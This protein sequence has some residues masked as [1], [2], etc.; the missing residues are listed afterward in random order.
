MTVKNWAV[1]AL[2]LI[3]AGC[4][5]Q[6]E[7]LEFVGTSLSK[8]SADGERISLFAA[9]EETHNGNLVSLTGHWAG[10][11][12]SSWEVEYFGY[13]P[14][15][16]YSGHALE[17][18][19]ARIGYGISTDWQGFIISHRSRLEYR[20]GQ[21]DEAVRYRPEVKV[22]RVIPVGESYRLPVYASYEAA[23]NTGDE[24]FDF[25]FSRAGFIFPVSKS[26][27]IEAGYLEIRDFKRDRSDSGVAAVVHFAL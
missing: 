13:F 19:R 4:F 17:D 26:L 21:L 1:M 8:S 25:G 7:P 9:H 12:K 10:D 11:S 24:R 6:S 18:H 5:A 27:K 2:L 14:R 15:H 22:M 3:S 16:P 20:T 23:Y